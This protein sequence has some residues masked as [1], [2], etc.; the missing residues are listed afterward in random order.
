MQPQPPGPVPEKPADERRA[1]PP[2]EWTFDDW[3]AI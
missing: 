2:R 3:A 1:A